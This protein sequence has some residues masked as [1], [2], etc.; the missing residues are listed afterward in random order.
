MDFSPGTL[1]TIS[2]DKLKRH[3]RGNLGGYRSAC[4]YYSDT[5]EEVSITELPFGTVYSIEQTRESSARLKPLDTRYIISTGNYDDPLE[6][7]SFVEKDLLVRTFLL[8]KE[9]K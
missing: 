7:T 1:V 9:L 3:S 2:K 8:Q 5:Q 4:V 6:C